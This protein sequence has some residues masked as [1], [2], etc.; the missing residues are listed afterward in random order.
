MGREWRP[1]TSAGCR[2]WPQSA[3][4]SHSHDAADRRGRRGRETPRCLSAAS[5][6][7]YP[8]VSYRYAAYIYRAHLSRRV[9][10]TK[11]WQATG[12]KLEI[13]WRGCEGGDHCAPGGWRACPR[14][15]LLL[16]LDSKDVVG[17][18]IFQPI[19]VL[20]RLRHRGRRRLRRFAAGVEAIEQRR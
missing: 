1:G 11:G 17:Q 13:T 7:T 19:R 9:E 12:R 6:W 3:A 15:V 16:G 14:G 4:R 2:T 18:R 20:H 5:G 10:R 8:W